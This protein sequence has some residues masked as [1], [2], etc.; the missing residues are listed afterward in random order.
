MGIMGHFLS[1]WRGTAPAHIE[2]EM[3]VAVQGRYS[4]LCPSKQLAG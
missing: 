3:A 2:W 4:A 1:V